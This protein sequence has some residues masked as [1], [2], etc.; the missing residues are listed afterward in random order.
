M[1]TAWE[2][3]PGKRNAMVTTAARSI[4]RPSSWPSPPQQGG[5]PGE[6]AAE[7][8]DE[9]EIAALEPAGRDRLFERDVDRRGAGVAVPV[10]VHEDAVHRQVDA[11]GGGLDDPQIGLMRN[12]QAHVLRR[13]AV[14]RQDALR[15]IH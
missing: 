1:P 5:A 11:L 12:E 10:D 2:P 4:S 9:H 3:C 8:D 15:A 14:A 6:S 13:E 7:S